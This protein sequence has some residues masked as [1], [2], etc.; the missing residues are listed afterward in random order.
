MDTNESADTTLMMDRLRRRMVANCLS[1]FEGVDLR[2]IVALVSEGVLK[3]STTQLEIAPDLVEI[4]ADANHPLRIAA[5]PGPMLVYKSEGEPTR[6][7]VFPAGMVLS[8]DQ[9]TRVAAHAFLALMSST[10]PDVMS[11]RAHRLISELGPRLSS[12]SRSEWTD[13]AL[14]L[15]DCLKVDVLFNLAGIRQCLAL[16]YVQG[17]EEFLVHVLR[18]SMYALDSLKLPFACPTAQTAEIAQTIVDI[19][20]NSLTLVEVCH[21]FFESLG[22]LPL[23]S[24][25]GLANAVSQW[26]Q[27]RSSD[28]VVEEILNWA[29]KHRSCLANYHACMV[30]LALP[31]EVPAEAW[32]DVGRRIGEVVGSFLPG[33]SDVDLSIPWEIRNDLAKHFVQTLEPMAPGQD[34]RVAA[35]AWWL[36]DQFATCI[37]SDSTL[38]ASVRTRTVLKEE[39]RSCHLWL[40]C[41]PPSQ[42]SFLRYGTLYLRS[43]WGYALLGSIDEASANQLSAV[44]DATVSERISKGVIQ[45]LLYPAFSYAGQRRALG[46][47]AAKTLQA[48]KALANAM[49]STEYGSAIGSLLVIGNQLLEPDF[50]IDAIRKHA[51]MRPEEQFLFLS[52]LRSL[53]HSE[54]P[55]EQLVWELLQD[56]EWRTAFLEKSPLS[57]IEVFSDAVAFLAGQDNRW[58]TSGAHFLALGAMERASDPDHRQA[59]F[60]LTVLVSLAAGTTSAVERVLQGPKRRHFREDV[61]YWRERIAAAL[62]TASPWVQGRLRAMQLSLAFV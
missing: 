11:P 37:G 18:P 35:L 7:S 56:S 6:S 8:S 48:A 53:A 4:V 38:L 60:A 20:R 39:A 45:C 3:P 55:P 27:S 59:L 17:V 31:D 52:G 15:S 57:V 2:T 14:E 30:C 41:R 33:A 22:H 25:Y 29:A 54:N 40:L 47:D 32:Q 42:P 50:V 49:S 46:G 26:R 44:T 10:G 34:E 19:A 36:A 24:D 16:K 62:P 23:S 1:P 12:E 28:R 43:P 5:P 61:A 58:R 9:A 21:R 13:A 51:T